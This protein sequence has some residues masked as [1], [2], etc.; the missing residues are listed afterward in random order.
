MVYIPRSKTFMLPPCVLRN[1]PSDSF[2]SDDKNFSWDVPGGQF[3]IIIG[4]EAEAFA[5][6]KTLDIDLNPR[7]ALG[8]GR[9]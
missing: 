3:G 5:S 4:S 9:R 6:K 2:S 7:S 1:L 8:R